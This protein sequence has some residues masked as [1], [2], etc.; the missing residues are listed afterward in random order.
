MDNRIQAPLK[1]LYHTPVS[2]WT[3]YI[4]I[5][6]QALCT[7]SMQHIN[8]VATDLAIQILDLDVHRHNW[9]L[10]VHGLKGQGEEDKSNTRAAHVKVAHEYLGITDLAA[11]STAAP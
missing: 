6:Y 11:R 10:M 4:I 1:W 8:D 9:S 3:I 2:A 5:P 7:A